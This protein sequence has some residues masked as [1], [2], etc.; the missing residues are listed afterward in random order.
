MESESKIPE[1]SARIAKL[2][3]AALCWAIM[4]C[5]VFGTERYFT[6]TYEPE[7]MPKSAWEYEQWFTLRAGRN[8]AVGKRIAEQV[9][10]GYAI[11]ATHIRSRLCES[12]EV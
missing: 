4:A 3:L 9:G 2:P 6:Y 10:W 7:T 1:R 11:N 12:V 5:P 8:Q